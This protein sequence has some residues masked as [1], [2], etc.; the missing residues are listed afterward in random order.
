MRDALS[1]KDSSLLQDGISVGMERETLPLL[2]RRFPRM[3]WALNYDEDVFRT[4]IAAEQLFGPTG[5]LHNTGEG[6]WSTSAALD[7]R[8]EIWDAAYGDWRPFHPS[9][10]WTGPP[11]MFILIRRKGVKCCAGFDNVRAVLTACKYPHAPH[12]CLLPA[13]NLYARSLRR[14]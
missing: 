14:F 5:K 7:V 1:I 9:A 13:P 12:L 4:G 8:F 10:V 6:I 3:G 2:D 11:G